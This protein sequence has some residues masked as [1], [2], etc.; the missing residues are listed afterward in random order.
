MHTVFVIGGA[1]FMGR[2]VVRHLAAND[3][4]VVATH[5]PGRPSAAEPG[6]EWLP[7]DLAIADTAHWPTHYDAVIYLAQSAR[8]REFPAG[9]DDVFRVNVA[10]VHRAAEHA[11]VAGAKRFIHMST[12]TVYAQ[13]R[14]PA[15]ETDAI[16]V[17]AARSFYAASKL[18]AEML[19]GPYSASFGVIQLRLF[20][21]YG[22]GQNERMLLPVIAG[23]VRDGVPIDLHGQSGLTCNPTAIG[24][25]AEAVRRC[26]SLD[27]SHIL[28]V[29]GPEVLTLRQ[30]AEAIGSVIGRKP[31]F[32][33][34]P[35]D[36]PVI[37]G[38]TSRLRDALGWQ[39]PTGFANGVGDWLAGSK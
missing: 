32:Q 13:T 10:A 11:R 4:R 35:N 5:R 1:G 29:A 3:L 22:P 34:N 20:I 36:P 19:L 8:W 37:V 18:A 9:T 30:A 27:G 21:P 16:P 33:S 6:V 39:P 2:H 38:D 28:N 7:A 14:E 23:K 15:R 17:G 31:R 24:D 25:V 26:L 12:G